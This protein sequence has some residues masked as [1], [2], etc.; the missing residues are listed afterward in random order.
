MSKRNRFPDSDMLLLLTKL[1]VSR[2]RLLFD[3]LHMQSELME[4][5]LSAGCKLQAADKRAVDMLADKKAG[6]ESCSSMKNMAADSLK[7]K[8]YMLELHT[9]ELDSRQDK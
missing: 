8:S 7:D 4:R 9:P 5:R 6:M 2:L 1:L 3:Q